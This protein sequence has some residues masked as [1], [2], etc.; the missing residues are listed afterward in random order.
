M[1]NYYGIPTTMTQKFPALRSF[2]SAYLHEDWR[3]EFTDTHLAV[4]YFLAQETDPKLL[5]QI[6]D[7]IDAYLNLKGS[8]Q[9][10]EK[11]LFDELGCY[12]LPSGEG[13]N[14]REWLRSVRDLMAQQF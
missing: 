10:V 5:K 7:E 14:P 1:A 9:E 11:G 4:K 2:F 13:L 12:Y 6:V 3:V 8:D